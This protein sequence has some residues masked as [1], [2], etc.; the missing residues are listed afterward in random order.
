MLNRDFPEYPDWKFTFEA[1][2]EVGGEP[3]ARITNINSAG[4]GYKL[5]LDLNHDCLLRRSLFRT[6]DSGQDYVVD[7]FQR[8]KN[9]IWFPKRGRVQ[10]I[11]ENQLWVITEAEV[12]ESLDFSRFEPPQPV[13]GTT[14]N[15]GK[16]NVRVHGTAP[17]VSQSGA[18]PNVGGGAVP[19]QSTSRSATPPTSRW[20]WWSSGLLM[21]S[22]VFLVTGLVFWRRK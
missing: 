13:V 7:E 16:G 19:Q 15:D 14:V 2:E 20:L 4:V 22:V 1:I 5:W 18:S 10:L 6:S 11:D 8:L 17:S 3:C 12:N 9:G 21:V